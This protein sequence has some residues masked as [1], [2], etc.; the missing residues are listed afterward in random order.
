MIPSVSVSYLKLVQS[1]KL[2]ISSVN[3]VQSSSSFRITY[4]C[5]NSVN[6]IDFEVIDSEYEYVK[7]VWLADGRR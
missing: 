7:Y 3:K 5:T 1:Y 4:S 6:I 2:D